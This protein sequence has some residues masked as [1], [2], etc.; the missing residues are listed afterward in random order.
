[1]VPQFSRGVG[2]GRPETRPLP[3]R[4]EVGESST[5]MVSGTEKTSCRT[6]YEPP[7]GTFIPTH[8]NSCIKV[9]TVRGPGTK[10]PREKVRK[11]R[12]SMVPHR[13]LQRW[14]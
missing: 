1:M 5:S 2:G 8:H 3:F 10:E 12:G 14:T 7:P 4:S 13:D 6:P 9:R 11:F